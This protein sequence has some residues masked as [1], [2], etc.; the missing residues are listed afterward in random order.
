MIT[1]AHTLGGQGFRAAPV[2]VFPSRVKKRQSEKLNLTQKGYFTVSF[3]LTKGNV[4][5]LFFLCLISSLRYAY[6]YLESRIMMPFWKTKKQTSMQCA[7]TGCA[8]QARAW[9][10]CTWQHLFKIASLCVQ[11]TS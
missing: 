9:H 11:S 7:L 2:P 4:P 6:T 1:L 8:E 10:V 3:C 5:W